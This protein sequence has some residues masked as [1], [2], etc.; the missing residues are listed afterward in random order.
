MVDHTV[1]SLCKA[2]KPINKKED[3]TVGGERDHIGDGANTISGMTFFL[4]G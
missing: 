3:I 1:L 4:P 2:E